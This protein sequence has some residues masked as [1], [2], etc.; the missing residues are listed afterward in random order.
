[1]RVVRRC[2]VRLSAAAS[3]APRCYSLP[4]RA[5]TRAMPPAGRRCTLPPSRATPTPSG[6]SR[7]GTP[8]V[9]SS[10]AHAT[11]RGIRPT[12]SP[13]WTTTRAASRRRRRPCGLCGRPQPRATSRCCSRRWPRAGAVW[14]GVATRTAGARVTFGS[15]RALRARPRS[16]AWHLF[17]SR[18]GAQNR[19][20]RR[21]SRPIRRARRS[22]RS[23]R[24]TDRRTAGT[25]ATWAATG[26]RGRA[27]AAGRGA[28]R[29]LGRRPSSIRSSTPRHARKSRSRCARSS[30]SSRATRTSTFWTGAAP[31]RS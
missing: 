22:H 4:E 1:M 8:S 24:S 29:R 17:T 5:T 21:R 20:S 11:A 14:H 12:P 10:A 26:R 3:T 30:S 15:P 31:H 23:N 2:S 28:S 27:R 16:T 19:P 9:G 25:S 13:R 6:C 7:S 18:S